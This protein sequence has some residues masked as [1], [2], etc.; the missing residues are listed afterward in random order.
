MDRIS[1]HSKLLEFQPVEPLGS[2]L[3]LAF[4]YFFNLL[5]I[6]EYHPA[7]NLVLYKSPPGL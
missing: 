5:Y 4:R 1:H 3:M 6:R 2:Q 7:D